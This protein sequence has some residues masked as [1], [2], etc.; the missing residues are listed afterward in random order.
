[1][2]ERIGPMYSKKS[3]RRLK[4]LSDG[5]FS[6]GPNIFDRNMVS[7]DEILVVEKGI[8]HTIHTGKFEEI[9]KPDDLIDLT[10]GVP[11][12]DVSCKNEYTIERSVKK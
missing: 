8:I 3:A 11:S 6:I 2:T 4:F 7:T 1:M 12:E 9:E 10:I 5:E